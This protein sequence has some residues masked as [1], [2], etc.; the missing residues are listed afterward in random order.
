MK[1]FLTIFT[2][3]SMASAVLAQTPATRAWEDVKNDAPNH[4]IEVSKSGDAFQ[5]MVGQSLNL[6]QSAS[7]YVSVFVDN[8]DVLTAHVVNPSLVVI[9]GKGPGQAALVLVDKNGTSTSYS[10]RVDADVAPLQSAV[11]NE[12]PFDR[13]HVSSKEDSVVLTGYVLSK[14]ELAAVEKLA[15]GY[16]KKV[17]NSLRVTPQHVREVRL[18]VKFVEIDRTK[19]QQAGVNLISLGKNVAMTGTGQSTTFAP[20]TISQG[21]AT[22]TISSVGQMLVFNQGLNIGATLQDLEQKNVLQ[23]L[24][25]PT[26]NALSGH[27]ASFLSGGEFPFPM[28]Q[29][30]SGGAG[31]TI[32]VQFMPY[33]VQLNFEPTVLDDGTI[34]LHVEPEVSALD[35][36]NE[37]QIDGYTIPA[38]DARK[39]STDIELRDGQ[40]FM[41]SGLLDHRVTNEWSKI[42]GIADIPILGLLFKS[43]SVQLSTTDLV[44]VVT[45]NLVD[46][47]EMPGAAPEVPRPPSP[48]L[49]K[50]RFDE[51]IAAKH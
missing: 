35:Y 24:A 45:A 2:L 15:S 46:P 6:H 3:V 31:T 38:I 29:P 7:Q 8:P 42:P 33:G 10:V 9:S 50:D 19:L 23:I 13:I 17:L 47:L 14:D 36:T 27:R 30:G 28:V 5:L 39:A 20:P 26:I 21:T 43:K 51:S 11:E 12:F 32:T 22:T 1:T 34:R 4:T 40:S 44:V 18:S 37:V 16:G 48:Y 25:E 41:L 49:D